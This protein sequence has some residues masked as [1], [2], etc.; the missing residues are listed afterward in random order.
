MTLHM[1]PALIVPQERDCACVLE[2]KVGG[3]A[4]PS[5]DH[6]MRT[7]DGKTRRRPPRVCKCACVSF[8][9]ECMPSDEDGEERGGAQLR[10]TSRA[11]VAVLQAW[12]Q[13][14]EDEDWGWKLATMGMMGVADGDNII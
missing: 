2:L 12:R 10:W 4:T 13:N 3:N 11:L 6:W 9:P 14:S 5:I 7:R 1:L 8:F